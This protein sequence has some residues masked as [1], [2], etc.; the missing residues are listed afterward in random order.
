VGEVVSN[1]VLVIIVMALSLTV[2]EFAHAWAA[3]WLGDDTAERQ[4]RLNLNPLNHADPIGTVLL[5]LFILLANGAGG[6]SAIF[7]LGAAGAD[8]SDELPSLHEYAQRD[9][10]GCSSGSRFELTPWIHYCFCSYFGHS[11]GVVPLDSSLRSRNASNA[12]WGQCC[13]FCVQYDSDLP[14]RWSEGPFLLL[15]GTDCTGF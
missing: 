14:P 12:L 6:G 13:A 15:K 3:K 10:V 5:P 7:R 4:G 9:D 11:R 2:H 8:E 1:A